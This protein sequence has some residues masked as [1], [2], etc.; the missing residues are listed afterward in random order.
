MEEEFE[1]PTHRMVDGDRVELTP[2][3]IAELLVQWQQERDKQLENLNN[4]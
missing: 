2:E 4:E 3:E 1:P